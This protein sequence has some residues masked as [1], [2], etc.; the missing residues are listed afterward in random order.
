M[1]YGHVGTQIAG[2]EAVDVTAV[3]DLTVTLDRVS[4][5]T[6]LLENN[7]VQIVVGNVGVDREVLTGDST[8]D[9]VLDGISI[10]GGPSSKSV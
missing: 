9:N 8:G 3:E 5:E 1:A 7:A 6:S 4:V 2:Q 10:Q